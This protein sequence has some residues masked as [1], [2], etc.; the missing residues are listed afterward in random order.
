LAGT[1]VLF[2]VA[3]G[4]GAVA[5]ASEGNNTVVRVIPIK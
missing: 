4:G 3:D 2:G 5:E 1:Y